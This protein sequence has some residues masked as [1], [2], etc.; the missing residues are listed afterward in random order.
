V[1]EKALGHKGLQI[2]LYFQGYTRQT[3]TNSSLTNIEITFR[4]VLDG[5]QIGC[6]SGSMEMETTLRLVLN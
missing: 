3:S 5:D 4:L 6:R 1:Q 2:I